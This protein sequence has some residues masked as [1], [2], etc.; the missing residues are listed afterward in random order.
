[1]I[2]RV[3]GQAKK[4][5]CF[6]EVVVATDDE[7]IFD[8]VTKEGAKAIMTRADHSSGTDR[9]AEAA[10]NL[11]TDDSGNVIINIQGDEPFI[12]PNAIDTLAGCFNNPGVNIA[13]LIKKISSPEELFDENVVKVITGKD[14]QA[15]YFSRSALPF[16][17]SK[18]PSDWL[19]AFSFFKHIGIYAY[20]ADTLKKLSMLNPS[21]LEKA[22]GLEQLRWI[23]NG[24]NI[25]TEETDYES[26]SVDTQED[27][28]KLTNKT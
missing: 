24:L 5:S 19:S 11:I 2:M 12:N 25:H 13:T 21:A 16:V 23:E 27:L 17:R 9:V 28:L 18:D 4:A 1:M 3:Y 14:R 22:E 6:S 10:E 15:V 20:R 7:R 26:I 8:H